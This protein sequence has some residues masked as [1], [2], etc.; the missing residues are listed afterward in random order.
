MKGVKSA[1]RSQ[2]ASW[3]LFFFDLARLSRTAVTWRLTYDWA[4]ALQTRYKITSTLGLL[5]RGDPQNEGLRGL[6][7]R[8]LGSK[9]DY[10]H[11]GITSTRLHRQ[12]CLLDSRTLAVEKGL[13][14][15]DHRMED[16]VNGLDERLSVMGACLVVTQE[17]I[18]LRTT[19]KRTDRRL[20]AVEERLGTCDKRMVSLLERLN[21]MENCLSQILVQLSLAEERYGNIENRVGNTEN[22]VGNIENR[23]GNI[24]NRVGNIENRVGNIENR[25][26]NIENRVGAVEQELVKMNRS[27]SLILA[28]LEE[29][30]LAGPG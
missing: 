4:S 13:G 3:C 9:L 30:E 8:A 20:R 6:Q 17:Q 10:F 29:R 23:V 21:Y 24:E 25:V 27:I 19:E 26:G 22:R 14:E 28:K 2:Q 7:P 15:I 11:A 18:A 5:V 1:R 12:L 16:R